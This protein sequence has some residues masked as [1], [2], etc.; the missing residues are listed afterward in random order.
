MV[1]QKQIKKDTQ[2][3]NAN[4][5]VELYI[6]KTSDQSYIHHPNQ[7]DEVP[8]KFNFV[9][10]NEPTDWPITRY[11][12]HYVR[13][14]ESKDS[15]WKCSHRF[16]RPRYIGKRRT[17]FAK[18]YGRKVRYYWKLFGEHVRNLGTFALR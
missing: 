3:A 1:D 2:F 12:Q 14:L 11:K 16:L 7:L 10:N 17:T 5:N 9:F 6:D 15:I 18:A 8:Q 13:F 4:N